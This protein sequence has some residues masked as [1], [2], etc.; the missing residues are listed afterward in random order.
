MCT[1]IICLVSVGAFSGCK[2]AQNAFAVSGLR[3]N[4]AGRAYRAPQTPIWWG[5]ARYPS[6]RTS[7]P[8]SA[9]RASTHAGT[10]ARPGV[11]TPD[12]PA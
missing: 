4:P 11:V 12:S 1:N 9:L 10:L 2:Y 5:G 7:L 8:L 3:P 6:P